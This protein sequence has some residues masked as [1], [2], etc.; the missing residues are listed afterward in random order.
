MLRIDCSHTAD[1]EAIAPVD[2]G[3]RQRV[4]DNTRKTCDIGHLGKG[5]VV[6]QLFHHMGVGIDTAGNQHRALS[7][8]LP[9]IIVDSDEFHESSPAQRSRYSSNDCSLR[10][11]DRLFP[12]AVA[13][14][15]R[16]F[17]IRVQGVGVFPNLS[18]PR[19]VWVGILSEELKELAARF[20]RA[21]VQCGFHSDSRPFTPHVTIARLRKARHWKAIRRAVGD[22]AILVFGSSTVER[23]N[24]YR[25]V[26]EGEVRIYEEIASFPLT[27][28]GA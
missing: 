8:N 7:G 6:A 11:C 4:A 23:I 18:Q 21:A 27:R 13:A 17:A 10:C 19:I 20:D 2:I 9:K 1:R 26:K 22:P 16:P 3:H 5:G 28:T 15:A 12:K 24:I 14:E 25:S